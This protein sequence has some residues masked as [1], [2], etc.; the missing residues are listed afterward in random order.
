MSRGFSRPETT[1][2][3][4]V[5]VGRPR[6][7]AE[8]SGK[9]ELELYDAGEVRSGRKLHMLVERCKHGVQGIVG[10]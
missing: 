3:S 1:V 10:A 8:S 5:C 4:P 2:E 6:T 7:D 9:E